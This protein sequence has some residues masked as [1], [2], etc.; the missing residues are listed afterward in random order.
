MICRGSE[1]IYIPFVFEDFLIIA[2]RDFKYENHP[3]IKSYVAL[4]SYE[5]Y[6][7]LTELDSFVG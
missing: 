2:V 6:T 4:F 1:L 5:R 7:V 3:G